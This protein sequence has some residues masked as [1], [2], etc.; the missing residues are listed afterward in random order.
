[1][2]YAHRHDRVTTQLTMRSD[3]DLVT[4]DAGGVSPDSSGNEAAC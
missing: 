3:G 1:M 4:V 2:R